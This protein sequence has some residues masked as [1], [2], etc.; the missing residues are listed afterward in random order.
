MTVRR[1]PP[2]LARRSYRRRRMADA[3]RLL[4]FLGLFLILLPI[5]WQPRLSPAPDTA[6]GGVY[7]F[8]VWAVLVLGAFG[9]SRVL[10]ASGEAEAGPPAEPAAGARAGETGGAARVDPASDD[11]ARA[12]RGGGD[13]AGTG[14]GEEPR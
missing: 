12:D 11:P 2:F 10:G 13:V 9:L 7:L 6:P 3:A 1:A 4:P 14:A 5:L 8:A